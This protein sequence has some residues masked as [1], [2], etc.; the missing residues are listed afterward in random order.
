MLR[1][2]IGAAA[3]FWLYAL[4]CAAGLL[5]VIVAVPETRG[6][7]KI[8][9]LSFLPFFPAPKFLCEFHTVYMYFYNTKII[10]CWLAIVQL[11]TMNYC[12]VLTQ[13]QEPWGNRE[14]VC[15]T[16]GASGDA[17]DAD[18]VQVLSL[19]HCGKAKETTFCKLQCKCR[20]TVCYRSSLSHLKTTPSQLLWNLY[21]SSCNIWAKLLKTPFTDAVFCCCKN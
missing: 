5:F 12:H 8:S 3:V 11:K 18:C 15:E 13:M 10:R 7:W 16:L 4:L 2:T 19:S 21:F 9:P 14:D 1:S 17:G 6:R 20:E